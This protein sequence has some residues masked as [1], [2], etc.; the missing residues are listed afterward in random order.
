[1]KKVRILSMILAMLM[2]AVCFVSCNEAGTGEGTQAGNQIKVKIGI[3][4]SFD[5]ET[6][7][8]IESPI[9]GEVVNGIAVNAEGATPLSVAQALATLRKATLTTT[10]G[11]IDTITFDRVTYRTGKILNKAEVHTI[12]V[13]GKDTDVNFYEF[14]RWEVT[15]NG[16]AAEMDTPLKDGDTV[17]IK[18][19]REVIEDEY[20]VVSK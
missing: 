7:E 12:K 5:V 6:Y 8:K 13:E 16:A 14:V 10:T 20:E 11:G 18:L 17:T 15:V 2:I 19:V 9:I 3:Y 1:M 4:S